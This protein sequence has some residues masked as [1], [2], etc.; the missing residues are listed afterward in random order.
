MGN[1]LKS[2]FALADYSLKP[3]DARAFD[4]GAVLRKEIGEVSVECDSFES[5]LSP[6]IGLHALVLA[7]RLLVI[8]DQPT[9]RGDQQKS[10]VVL[11]RA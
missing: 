2:R 3:R 1:S 11:L 10:H 7:Q 8:D 5:K 9:K 6:V 4:E